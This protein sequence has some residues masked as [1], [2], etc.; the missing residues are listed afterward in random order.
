M[1]YPEAIDRRQIG[2]NIFENYKSPADL[3]KQRFLKEIER[4]TKKNSEND[5]AAEN[6]C[7]QDELEGTLLKL[8][9]TPPEI[10]DPLTCFG[11][12]EY[13][14][15]KNST[16]TNVLE[17]GILQAHCFKSYGIPTFGLFKTLMKRL[18]KKSNFATTR[19]CK[20]RGSSAANHI[21]LPLTAILQAWRKIVDLV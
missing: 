18:G 14:T 10:K 7:L 3:V 21:D 4:K 5:G 6:L 1:S 15:G 11:G 9:F 20:G 2:L 8:N 19:S 13:V 16:I 12:V 17:G